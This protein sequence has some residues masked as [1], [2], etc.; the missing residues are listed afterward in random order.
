MNFTILNLDTIGHT[1]LELSL[2]YKTDFCLPP[3]RLDDCQGAV[4][5]ILH[6]LICHNFTLNC[7]VQWSEVLFSA[8]KCSEVECP[9]V[10]WIEVQYHAVQFTA[11][12][13]LSHMT[14][15]T[16]E[17]WLQ[18]AKGGTKNIAHWMLHP[19]KML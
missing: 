10:Q 8:A 13:A 17:Q 5:G 18:L 14:N 12:R 15:L 16:K 3:E 6:L 2:Q 4:S 19:L 11:V 1:K 7:A 9:A